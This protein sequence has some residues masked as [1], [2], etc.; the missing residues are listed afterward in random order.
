MAD[1]KV[2]G[3]P[4]DSAPTASDYLLTLDSETSTTKKTLISALFGNITG[5][6]GTTALAPN[7]VTAAKLGTELQKGWED[8]FG[9]TTF[10]APNTIT[11]SGNRSYSLVF[12]TTDLTSYIS[13]GMRLKMTR[14]VTAPVQCADLETSSSQYATRV[15]ASVTGV[16]FTDDFTIEGWVKLESYTQGMILSRISGANGWQLFINAS[17][18]V[19]FDAYSSPNS[20][21]HNTWQTIPLGRWV[22]VAATMDASAGSVA[23][24]LDGVSA[25]LQTLSSVAT[26][27]TQ[28]GDLQIGA[29]GGATFF[30]GKISDVRLWNAVRS[31]AQILANMTQ[32]LGGSETNLI[33]YWKLNGN[34][35]DS[36][37]NANNLTATGGALATNADSPFGVQADGTTTGTTE[38][39]VVMKAVFS[40]NTTLTVQVPEGNAI[41]TSGGVSAVS[42]SS[43]KSPY[44]MPMQ[45]SR[46]TIG[47]YINATLNASGAVSGTWYNPANYQLTIPAGSWRMGY[48]AEIYSDLAGAGD[49][50]HT[51]S[52]STSASAVTEIFLNGNA[53]ASSLGANAFLVSPITREINAELATATPYYG[54]IRTNTSTTALQL[55]GNNVLF[56]ECAYL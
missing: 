43:V 20:R 40:T 8:T 42:Y 13:P 21:Q 5:L 1:V 11:Y 56:A 26:S 10:P 23:I 30:D 27:I 33:G 16:T 48:F 18:Q 37:S 15:S 24:Y 38:Y 7:A 41:P 47:T 9:T 50:Y 39:G 36:T 34:F 55:T 35:N 45:R 4:A 53:R 52:M 2:S 49:K 6:I 44:G 3:L 17:G 22:H 28:A 12:N 54:I 46:W 29:G 25:P 14:T 31:N 51:F 19:R 32:Q